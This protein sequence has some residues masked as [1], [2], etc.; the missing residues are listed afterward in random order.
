MTRFATLTL[1]GAAL[2]LSTAGA[3]AQ[4]VD[5][6]G[7][8]PDPSPA[9]APETTA[10]TTPTSAP[11]STPARAEDR[12]LAQSIAEA[13][14]QGETLIATGREGAPI[15][16]ILDVR[17]DDGGFGQYLIALDPALELE[18]D[19]VTFRG[20]VEY[21]GGGSVTLSMPQADFTGIVRDY[22]PSQG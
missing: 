13:V 3:M 1:A 7:G 16:R 17:V 15:G 19:R 6:T 18:V 4:D 12:L 10:E 2:A 8:V 22:F 21:D 20:P 9:M 5:R 14:M 11:I